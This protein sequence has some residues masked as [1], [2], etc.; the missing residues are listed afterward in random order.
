M[1]DIIINL[2]QTSFTSDDEREEFM[3]SVEGEDEVFSFDCIGVDVK[4][5]SVSFKP[6]K[7][8]FVFLF[9][10]E[11]YDVKGELMVL[12]ELYPGVCFDYLAVAPGKEESV[13]SILIEAGEVLNSQTIIGPAAILIG[14]MVKGGFAS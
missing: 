8:G 6:L 5:D 12:S 1:S 7:T 2:L 10:T 9:L 11:D 4:L 3:K 14:E 13:N